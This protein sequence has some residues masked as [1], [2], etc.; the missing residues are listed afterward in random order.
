MKFYDASRSLYLLTDASGIGLGARLLQVRDGMKCAHD[1]VPDNATMHPTA[2]ACKSLPNTE[3]H[4]S[5]IE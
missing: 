3:W 2:F 4:Y 1:E 5:N